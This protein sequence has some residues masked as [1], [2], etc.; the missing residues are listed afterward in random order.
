MRAW[1]YGLVLSFF[2]G[3]SPAAAIDVRLELPVTLTSAQAVEEIDLVA[4]MLSRTHPGIYQYQSRKQFDRTVANAKAAVKGPV[5]AAELDGASLCFVTGSDAEMHL[6][7]YFEANDMLFQGIEV[8]DYAILESFY[9]QSRCYAAVAIETR[10]EDIR[11][12]IYRPS[13]HVILPDD[14]RK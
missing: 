3:L 14:I 7:R 9:Y 12:S 6:K 8:I 13:T 11:R 10:V 4:R 5:N 2:A 1:I